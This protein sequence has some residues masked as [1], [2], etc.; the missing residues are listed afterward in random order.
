MKLHKK[1][2]LSCAL[3]SILV[4]QSTVFCFASESNIN[5]TL[6]Q[7]KN[8]DVYDLYQDLIE[9][10][11]I[12]ISDLKMTKD[13]QISYILHID[14]QTNAQVT[15]I[16]NQNGD[17]QLNIQE[18]DL[19]NELVITDENKIYL[20]GNEVI[21]N[22]IDD[23]NDKIKDISPRALSS[24]QYSDVPFKG[25]G[26]DYRI[27]SG[28]QRYSIDL[29]ED[30]ISI[31][32]TVLG[33]ILGA[34]LGNPLFGYLGGAALAKSIIDVLGYKVPYAETLYY[35][36]QGWE[37]PKV[38]T[39]PMVIYLKHQMKWFHDSLYESEAKDLCETYY[40]KTTIRDV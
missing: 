7:M 26:R 39:D 36:V 2:I 24:V 6:I 28:A 10:N 8:L 25:E 16:N 33:T 14:E 27:T 1:K 17:V 32:V 38:N 37:N 18:E 3:T 22:C 29:S 35:S 12:Q 23:E 21:V 40:S 9:E 11:I 5:D 30:I 13:N 31:G 15:Q 34:A 20:N 4:L 19:Y